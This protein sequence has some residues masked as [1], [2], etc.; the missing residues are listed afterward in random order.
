[1]IKKLVCIAY[2]LWIVIAVLAKILGL[3][4]WGFA[5]SWLWLPLGIALSVAFVIVVSVGIGDRLKKK[6]EVPKDCE[7]CLFN[8][9]AKYDKNNRCLGEALD[10][11][12]KRGEKPCSYFKQSSGGVVTPK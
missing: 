7:H 5:L 12:I 2:G 9:T 10:E 11:S 4:G 3:A 6:I 1:M 8:D